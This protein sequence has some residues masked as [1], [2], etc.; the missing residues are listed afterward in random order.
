MEPEIDTGTSTADVL[1]GKPISGRNIFDPDYL[2]EQ[3]LSLDLPDDP[4]PDEEDEDEEP[5]EEPTESDPEPEEEEQPEQED[6]EDPGISG[7]LKKYKTP[8]EIAK[9]MVNLQKKFGEHA[10]ELGSL[11]SR[12]E[13][14]LELVRRA[15]VAPAEQEQA[16]K[17][18]DV[19][20][21]ELGV[22]VVPDTYWQQEYLP[23]LKTYYLRQYLDAGYEEAEARSLAVIDAVE[24]MAIER[25][26]WK[27]NYTQ[28]R[29]EA[30]TKQTEAMNQQIIENSEKQKETMN[31]EL[32]K[33]GG[34]SQKM[35]LDP[36]RAAAK[37]L[38][39]AQQMVSRA[40]E[41][42]QIT[43]LEASA[44]EAASKAIWGAWA[45]LQSQ[46]QLDDLTAEPPA[47]R[48][49]HVVETRGGSSGS[50]RTATTRTSSATAYSKAHVE[51]AKQLNLTAE[52][53]EKRY[54]KI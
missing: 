18:D 34:L 15:G 41:T 8:E 44:P 23:E 5:E 29:S 2:A 28:S 49:P 20:R 31:A 50:A 6:D 39:V 21:D 10:N 13:A 37:V 33:I 48:A 27:E 17:E 1:D 38:S 46:G 53:L 11:R 19:L 45:Y 51:F 25:A 52:E 7:V 14:L 40:V 35:G 3:G 4:E 36:E 16:P 43:L 24:K 26:K 47:P 54:G 22:P 9:A 32:A 12:E 42:K 30:L